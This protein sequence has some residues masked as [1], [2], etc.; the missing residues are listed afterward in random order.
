[1]TAHPSDVQMRTAV[2]WL[3]VTDDAARA[4]SKQR[5]Q[6]SFDRPALGIRDAVQAA[7]PDVNVKDHPQPA[8]APGQS[9]NRRPEICSYARM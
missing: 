7:D 1:M 9:P 4:S 8:V 2:G 5:R 3:L 6:R